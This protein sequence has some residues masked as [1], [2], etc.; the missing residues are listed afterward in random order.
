M[1]KTLTHFVNGAHVAGTG[2]RLGDVF[3]PATGEVAARVPLASAA[4]TAAAIEA[5]AADTLVL[6]PEE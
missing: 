2:D 4:E 1:S 5:A 3:N 6:V